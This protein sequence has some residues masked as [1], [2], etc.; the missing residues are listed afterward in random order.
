[1]YTVCDSAYWQT[2]QFYVCMYVS[3]VCQYVALPGECYYNT[4]LCCD[5]VSS[6]SV[7][8]CAFSVLCMYS[9]LRH[10]PHSLGYHC[11]KFHFFCGLHCSASPRRKIA[12]SIT[13]SL[14][15]LTWCPGNQSLRFRIVKHKKDKWKCNS[16]GWCFWHGGWNEDK[17]DRTRH[18]K[19]LSLGRV[20]LTTDCTCSNAI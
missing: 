16:H 2:L 14:T 15:Q 13:H 10:H 6:S 5:Y 4:V 19:G 17:V 7:V 9:K 20:R 3:S 8:L 12:Y 11:A 18:C 1:M